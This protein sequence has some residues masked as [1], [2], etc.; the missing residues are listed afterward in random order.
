MESDA[1]LINTS[2]DRCLAVQREDILRVAET[3]VG[4][5]QVRLRVLPETPLSAAAHHC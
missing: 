3:Y 5:N 2:L 4:N 1:G